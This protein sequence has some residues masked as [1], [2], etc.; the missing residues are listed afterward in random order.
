MPMM[1]GVRGMAAIR[2]I[3]GCGI[4][5]L[6]MRMVRGDGDVEGKIEEY[7]EAAPFLTIGMS[8]TRIKLFE[9]SRANDAA[10]PLHLHNDLHTGTFRWGF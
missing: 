4:S 7:V 8:D 3:S 2:S 5:R 9:R 10:W 6:G 1:N